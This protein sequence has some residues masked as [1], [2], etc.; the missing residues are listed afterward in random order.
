MLFA[1][2]VGASP[3][4]KNGSITKRK[5]R[6]VHPHNM[7]NASAYI[8]R[9]GRFFWKRCLARATARNSDEFHS[10]LA[11]AMRSIV[12]DAPYQIY[13]RVGE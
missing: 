8:F 9:C 13:F 1:D 3:L 4:R 11:E 2:M 12:L 10:R 6:L 5:G 7:T